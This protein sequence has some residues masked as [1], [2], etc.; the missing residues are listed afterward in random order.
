M[1]INFS[2][3]EFIPDSNS[4]FLAGPTTRKSSFELSWR[5]TAC[6]YLDMVLHYDGVVY[7]PEFDSGSLSEDDLLRQMEWEKK[8]LMGAGAILFNLC[9][10]FPE[11]PGLTTNVEFGRYLTKRP[12][13]TILC[14]PKDADKNRYLEWQFLDER[15][16]AIIYRELNSALNA[17]VLVAHDNAS[18]LLH[19]PVVKN[20]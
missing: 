5:N 18:G 10:K 1:K 16:E 19:M 11:N 8:G 13:N 6:Q 7:V 9:R 12:N 17:A 4:I 3:Q 15:P 14:S 2:N 20:S